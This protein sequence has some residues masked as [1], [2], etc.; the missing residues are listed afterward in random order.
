MF[1]L[2]M[3][4]RIAALVLMA[5]L[6]I[7]GALFFIDGGQSRADTYPIAA[8]EQPMYVHVCGAVRKPGVIEVKAP[9]RKFE[10]LKMAGGTLPEA[11]LNRVNLA[12]F[13][14]D[15]EQVYIPKQGEVLP[16]N[17]RSKSRSTG[18]RSRADGAA[19]AAE[20]KGP[21]DLNRATAAELETVPGIGPVLAAKIIE[22]RTQHGVFATYDDL[23]NVSG[24][25]PVKLEKFRSF[26]YVK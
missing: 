4:Q 20:P 25:G 5:L 22:Y 1:Q 16:E 21:F 6:V 19:K 23:G 24:I 14:Q 11:D 15:G 3:P 9:L 7:A 26:L 17:S 2:T 18:A 12:E 10:L 8:A 13:V